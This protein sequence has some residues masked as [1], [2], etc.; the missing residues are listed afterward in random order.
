MKRFLLTLM[1]LSAATALAFSGSKPAGALQTDIMS[2]TVIQKM[3]IATKAILNESFENEFF[4]PIGWTLS[5]TANLWSRSDL[6]SGYGIGTGSAKAD[7]YS[8]SSGK[9]QDLIT[10]V[11]TPSGSNDSLYFD[12]AYASYPGDYT[13]SLVIWTSI[14]GGSNWV[15]LICLEGGKGGPLNTGGVE[16]SSYVPESDEWATKKYALPAG[17]DRMKF[18]GYSDF[19]NCL[20]L[21]NIY[22]KY[23]QQSIDATALVIK[24]PGS[25]QNSAVVPQVL[26]KNQGTSAASFPVN[27]RISYSGN[28]VYSQSVNVSNLASGDTITVIFPLWTPSPLG[29]VFDHT[30]WTALSGDLVKGNDTLQGFTYGYYSPRNVMTEMFTATSC[31]PC[32]AANDS[33]NQI[34]ADLQDSMVLVRYHVWWPTNNDPFYLNLLDDTMDIRQ[35][36]NYYGL[37]FVPY[38]IVGGLLVS[39]ST[40]SDFR[41]SILKLC[42]DAVSPL[43]LVLSGTYDST[44][45]SG[46]I[47]ATLN[48]T[49]RII[50]SDLRLF[51]M[52]IQDSIL[53]T[54]TNG[55]PIHHQVYRQVLPTM[56]GRSIAIN[57]GETLRDSATFSIPTTGYAPPYVEEDCQVIAFLQSNTTKNIWQS[58]RIPLLSLLTGVEGEPNKGPTVRTSLLPCYPNPASGDVRLSYNLA[59]EGQVRLAIY[60]VMGRRV[61]SLVNNRQL[62]GRHTITWD[63]RSDSGAKVSNG[64]YFYKLDAEGFTSTKKLTILK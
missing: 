33:M 27:F 60:D 26:V 2:T 46:Q 45:K 21:D 37:N 55:D 43:T 4:P 8:F 3:P 57:M 56:D 29:E 15:Y 18:V 25:F 34:F 1:T 12:H 51:Y 10:F 40:S 7:F 52:I 19:G 53:Y 62:P 61:K 63:G 17:T 58:A 31:P 20:Y 47:I 16:S 50:D 9:Y 22:V 30:V 44:A 6:C 35:R 28:E 11:C 14:D 38:A 41:S 59:T 42:Q 39:G 23:P 32:V 24:S 5:G 36:R 54:G 64:V 13:D 48:S 49:G